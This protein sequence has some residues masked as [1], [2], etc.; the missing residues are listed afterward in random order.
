MNTNSDKEGY[1]FTLDVGINIFCNNS[2]VEISDDNGI[3][4]V[5]RL[6]RKY[7]EKIKEIL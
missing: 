2:E 3:T 1:L 7:V 6:L 5:M 4:R